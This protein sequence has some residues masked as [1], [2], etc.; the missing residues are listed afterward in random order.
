VI[1]MTE[2]TFMIDSMEFTNKNY[3][4]VLDSYNINT[5]M[6]ICVTRLSPH[7]LMFEMFYSA[8]L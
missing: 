8:N 2:K 4:D 5:K 3:G 7:H 1:K 6:G